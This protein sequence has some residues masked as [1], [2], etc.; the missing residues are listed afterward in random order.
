LKANSLLQCPNIPCV[1]VSI[2]TRSIEKSSPTL[3]VSQR[4]VRLLRRTS[5]ASPQ[6]RRRRRR[7][8]KGLIGRVHGR[9][10]HARIRIIV[11]QYYGCG[12]GRKR[13][14]S[15]R[16][17]Q[18]T[19]QGHGHGGMLTMCARLRRGYLQCIEFH[20][21]RA[22]VVVHFVVAGIMIL[23]ICT[24]IC[25]VICT[26]ICIATVVLV[27]HNG[28]GIRTPPRTTAQDC[29]SEC[30]HLRAAGAST[31]GGSPVPVSVRGFVPVSFKVMC[32]KN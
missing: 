3:R 7:G 6:Q 17:Q 10:Q 24:V 22:V 5:I 19:R 26:A 31:A 8:T 30:S 18:V 21:N 28:N 15:R 25:T 14:Q 9:R 23:L 29:W 32:H 2:T 12:F 13:A 20:I 27:A 11:V 16:P 4:A 1:S